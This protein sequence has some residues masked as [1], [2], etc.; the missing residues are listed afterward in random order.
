MRALVTGGGI[1]LT[2]LYG[3]VCLIYA[4]FAR[5]LSGDRY[6]RAMKR[7]PGAQPALGFEKSRAARIALSSSSDVGIAFSMSP[8]T[9][10]GAC[11]F[12]DTRCTTKTM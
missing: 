8:N 5:L 10:C 2:V 7:L 6:L 3:P 1:N 4:E 11:Q 12:S 9:L